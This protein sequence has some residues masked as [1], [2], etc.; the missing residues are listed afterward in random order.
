MTDSALHR[1][2]AD[3]AVGVGGRELGG[4]L[5]GLGTAEAKWAARREAGKH[6]MPPVALLAQPLRQAVV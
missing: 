3:V 1:R 4:D 5:V 6:R 2:V